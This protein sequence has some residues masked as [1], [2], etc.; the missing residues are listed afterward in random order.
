MAFLASGAL[1]AGLGLF[2]SSQAGAPLASPPAAS[3][4]IHTPNNPVGG[5]EW[6]YRQRVNDD[7]TIPYD[8]IDQARAQSVAM[9]QVAL[10][11]TDGKAAS[12]W[13]LTGPSN[14]G[15]R[16]RE[17]APDPTTKGVVYMAAATGGI[18]K[19]T[20]S[21]QT[22]SY[23]WDA[24]YP[25][26][27][28]A[29]AVDDKGTVWAGSGEPDNGGGSAYY[30]DGVYKSTDGGKTWTNMGLT[31]SGSI[32]HIAI[33]PTDRNRIFAAAQGRLHDTKGERG[34]YLT[35][36][37]GKTWDEVIPGLKDTV[38]AIDVAID[39]ANPKIVLATT[40][41]K[42]RDEQSRIYG[43][44][45]K[46]YRS[47]DGGKTWKDKQK[48]PLPVSYDDPTKPPADTY[49]G[50]MGIGFSESDPKIVYLISTTSAGNF[51]GFFVSK[52]AGDSWKAVGATTGGVLQQITG[53]FAWWFGR[54]WV[55]PTDSKHVFVAGVS[56]AES[57]NGGETWTTSASVHADQH[58]LAWD[59]FVKNRAYLGNDGGFYRSDDNAHATGAWFKTP[60]L[61][62]SQFYAMDSSLQHN[63]YLNGG[64]QDNNSL[65]SWQADGSVTGNWVAYVGGDGMMN[66]IDPEDDRYYYGCSQY[67][68]CRAFTPNG[69]FTIG[70][71]GPRVNWVAPLEFQLT[72]TK[73]LYGGGNLL[74]RMD[75]SKTPPSW[76]TISPDLSNGQSP[77]G[78]TAFATITAI[79]SSNKDKDLLYAGTDDGN[80]WVSHNASAAASKVKWKKIK[81]PA[82]P[83]RWVTRVTVSPYKS[84]IAAA[85]FSGWK[86]GESS[87][88]V[89]LTKNNGK[90]WKDISGDLPSAPVTD[91]IWS[92]KHDDWMYVSTDVGV[93]VTHNMGKHW[94]KIGTNLPMV[95]VLDI[96]IQ[97]QTGT[98]YAATYG[99]SIW[100]TSIKK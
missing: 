51:N 68:G 75:I 27:M 47:D 64:T 57:T 60:K 37:G 6:L 10:D 94:R 69:G 32:G 7:G 23:A 78:G 93:F 52:D 70:I 76:E 88:H 14:I 30:G 45:S 59:P 19:S 5:D 91:V 46:L 86:W 4:V 97:P 49:V 96:D 24:S 36:D 15:G 42:I 65:K 73:I 2:S 28:G 82:V 16:V 90:T 89:A 20:D 38:G 43:K 53:G 1:V 74:H 13:K 31:K 92:P 85:T 48:P 84:K 8:V 58:A 35:T 56:L 25:Q 9:G 79:G 67:G 22:F 66:R 95:P 63:K 26:S 62:T 12:K 50:R 40:W 87:P 98:L 29:V 39:P 44:G 72:D 80:L 11:K 3:P 61:P 83:Q 33:D 99:R 100:Q 34:L 54:V 18:W 21:G 71:P 17:L 81:S 41:D 55:D 77:R